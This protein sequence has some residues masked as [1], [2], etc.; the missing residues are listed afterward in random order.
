MKLDF[1]PVFAAFGIGLATYVVLRLKKVTP[2]VKFKDVRYN[3]LKNEVQL[4]VENVSDK[5]VFV[6]PAIRLVKLT[7]PDEWK[8]RQFSDSPIPMMVGSAGSVIKGYELIGE[9]A[10]PVAIEPKTTVII[11][12]PVMRDFGLNS[13][14]NIKVDSPVGH[15]PV[16]LV[17]SVS[18][19]IRMNIIGHLTE[20]S[21]EELLG[22]LNDRLRSENPV[23]PAFDG[24]ILKESV[25][26]PL[27]GLVVPGVP[28]VPESLDAKKSGFPVE[29]MCY[30]C[31]K[32]RWLSWVVG[33][34]HVCQ[35]CKDFLG[36]GVKLAVTSVDSC[37][38]DE[39]LESGLGLELVESQHVDLKPRHRKILDV[40]LGENTLSIKELSNKLERDQKSVATDLRFLLKNNLVDRVKIKGKYKY[41][42]LRDGGQVVLL[43][44]DGQVEEHADRN[45]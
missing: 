1:T 23:S 16:N 41:F 45:N 42:S 15:D 24:G 36:G 22:L 19:T 18:N 28:S 43:N 25:I 4:V 5:G 30:C 37:E 20:E 26:E 6:K 12:Y 34:N 27:P 7:S 9:Y 29:A 2:D 21:S 13:Y 40:L 3:T 11:S 35:E 8:A 17:G 38:L 39:E 44:S 33:G 31:G 32:E 14:D 10:E